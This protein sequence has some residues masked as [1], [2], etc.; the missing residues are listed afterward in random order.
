[1]CVIVQY[2]FGYTLFILS[3]SIH[4]DTDTELLFEAFIYDINSI[5]RPE[6][7]IRKRELDCK[8]LSG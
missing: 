3:D 2:D 6:R 4:N 5:V 1:M 8:L 7:T